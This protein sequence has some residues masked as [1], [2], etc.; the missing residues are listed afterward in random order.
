MF[1]LFPLFVLLKEFSSCS[2]VLVEHHFT[3]TVV[4][5]QNSHIFFYLGVDP[6]VM[7]SCVKPPFQGTV[8]LKSMKIDERPA[9]PPDAWKTSCTLC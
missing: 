1:I 6:F 8:A 5:K 2:H 4:K 7:Q 9:A 3:V